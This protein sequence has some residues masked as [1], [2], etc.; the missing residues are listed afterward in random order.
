[1]ELE[2]WSLKGSHFHFGEQGLGQ[3]NTRAFWSSDGL[4]SALVAR[5][6]VLPPPCPAVEA[7]MQPFLAQQPPFVL[8][9]LF[10]F[11]G[12]VLFFPV[13]LAA[14][15]PDGK[16][17][18]GDVRP[19]EL[20]KV[21]FVSEALYRRLL[22]GQTLIDLQGEA[23][24]L[25]AETVWVSQAELPKLPKPMRSGEGHALWLIEKRPRVT[26]E[27]SSDRS[28]LFHVGA[29][30]FAPVCGLWFG[31]QWLQKDGLHAEWFTPL[32]FDLGEAGVGAER[33]VG[34][35]RGEF[36]RT[37]NLTL[38]DPQSAWTS[39]SR[40]L[41]RPQE[42]AA[43]RHP[44]AAWKVQTVG[45]WLVSPQKGG[46]RRR[47]VQMVQEG[48]TLGLPGESRPPFGRVADVRPRYAT[49]VEYPVEH[50]VYRCGYT[51]AIGFG[52]EA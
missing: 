18:P 46:Q 39:L 35:G 9:S 27:R 8:T 29:V 33:S 44:R 31:V 26:V 43:F 34:Y 45:G 2:I 38:P 19:K 24:R 11:A 47:P 22:A 17:L 41:P 36:T 48:A 14:T 32:L 37:G 7:W 21:Q 25:Q 5:L 10:P 3:E 49:G 42:M 40:Y 50:A 6:A 4:F 16:P 23:H 1:M 20:K 15:L 13:P 30:H 52:G 51:V 12:E 28:L